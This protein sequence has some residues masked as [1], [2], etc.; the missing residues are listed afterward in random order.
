MSG[1]ANSSSQPAPSELPLLDLLYQR[2]LANGVAGLAIVGP[3]RMREIEPHAAGL[4]ALHVPGTGIVDYGAVARVLAD[5][6]QRRGAELRTSTQ[7]LGA[8]RRDSEWILDTS[9]GAVRSKYLITCGGLYA[10]R[11]A[12][13][14]GGPT[15]LRIIPF[16]GEYYA[17]VPPR[18]GLVRAM[19]YPMP[20]PALPFLGVHFTRGIDGSVHAGPNAVLA[21]RREGYRRGDV[22]LGDM[23]EMARFPGFWRMVWT[24]RSLGL[25]EC[26]RALDKEAFVRSL[27]RLVPG[28]RAEDLVPGGSGVRAQAGDRHGHLIDDFDIVQQERAVHVRNVPS[29]AATASIR[30]GRIIAEQVAS[31]L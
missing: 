27:Q 8:S 7:V 9:Q 15:D 19:I 14:A 10:D 18:R 22:R 5:L 21:L 11:L 3:E 26:V 13:M 30:I 12:R 25:S 20:N 23:L 16:R 24:Y 2:G 31:A 28:V 17:L 1:A 4:K 29:P 6:I